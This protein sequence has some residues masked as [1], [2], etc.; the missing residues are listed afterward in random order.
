[1]SNVD[2][3]ECRV[4]FGPTFQR[5]LSQATVEFRNETRARCGRWT[6]IWWL[7]TQITKVRCAEHPR[8][9]SAIN[10]NR[11]LMT[12][13]KFA[14]RRYGIQTTIRAH[15]WNEFLFIRFICLSANSFVSGAFD[16]DHPIGGPFDTT[17]GR[18]CS[19]RWAC[20]TVQIQTTIN[21]ISATSHSITRNQLVNQIQFIQFL[22]SVKMNC[23]RIFIVVQSTHIEFL[24]FCASTVRWPDVWCVCVCMCMCV[25]ECVCLCFAKAINRTFNC[26]E[27]LA[28]HVLSDRWKSSL[29]AEIT[30][31][32]CRKLALPQTDLGYIWT[33]VDLFTLVWFVF[34]FL[35]RPRRAP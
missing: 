9:A 29:E 19:T 22:I 18:S 34:S 11:L 33:I 32:S 14:Q 30:G 12:Q 20:A 2:C 28:A 17:T 3:V 24:I 35:S 6:S 27:R 16:L 31:R 15:S 21:S 26:V 7:I 10:G 4:R 13:I 8:R 5:A 1:M 25:C 23:F